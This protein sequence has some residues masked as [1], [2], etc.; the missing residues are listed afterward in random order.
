MEEARL[1]FH[2][3]PIAFHIDVVE[4]TR[5]LDKLLSEE[6]VDMPNKGCSVIKCSILTVLPELS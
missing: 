2:P 6:S 4:R 1:S 5:A 3:P